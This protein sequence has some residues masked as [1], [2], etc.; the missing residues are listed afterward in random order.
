MKLRQ[1]VL[2]LACAATSVAAQGLPPAAPQQAEA[3]A[4][5]AAQALAPAGARIEARAGAA[6]PRLR[7]A[8]CDQVEAFLPPGQRAWGRT[9][10]GLRCRA[11][12]HWSVTLPVTVKVFAPAPVAAQALPTGTVLDATLLKT[13]EIDWAALAAPVQA[14][15][16]AL[17]GRT[18]ARPL[19]AGEAITSAD[20]R[21]RQWFA[22]GD[23]VRLVALGPGFAVS[24]EGQA[25]TPGLEG[26]T[27]RVKTESGRVVSGVPD[28]E[29]RMKVLP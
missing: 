22:A 28:G 18:L 5:Q 13:A 7:L 27:A 17:E 20:L 21:V 19:A 23:T 12:A 16:D 25:M 15:A 26:Q 11:G 2:P 3:L 9:R 14:R 29:R 4:R 24:A 8:P 6:D 10:V 1:C